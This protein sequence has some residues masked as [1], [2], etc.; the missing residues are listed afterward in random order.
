MIVFRK[1][2]C[3]NDISDAVSGRTLVGIKPREVTPSSA[4]AGGVASADSADSA[5]AVESAGGV[6][7]AGAADSTDSIGGESSADTS[8]VEEIWNASAMTR[9]WIRTRM[10]PS[11]IK[12]MKCLTLLIGMS[13]AA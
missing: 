12:R 8:E 11:I 10:I 9:L 2:V 6:G 13:P 3:A 7:S 1:T 4:E 5:G